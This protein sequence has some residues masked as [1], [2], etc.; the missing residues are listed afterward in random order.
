[1]NGNFFIV[2]LTGYI[3]YG[4][5]ELVVAQVQIG[6]VLTTALCDVREVNQAVGGFPSAG[7]GCL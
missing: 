7:G 4:K 2:L 1:M 3:L 5:A 6:S